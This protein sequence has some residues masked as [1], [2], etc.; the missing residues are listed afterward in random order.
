MGFLKKQFQVRYKGGPVVFVGSEGECSEYCL[1]HPQWEWVTEPVPA[2]NRQRWWKRDRPDA[3]RSG[4]LMSR[5]RER[6]LVHD[7]IARRHARRQKIGASLAE[8]AARTLAGDV[9]PDAP[10]VQARG[11]LTA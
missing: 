10:G 5:D 1:N 8:A 2:G 9:P 4:T 3:M 6:D 11:G 7:K